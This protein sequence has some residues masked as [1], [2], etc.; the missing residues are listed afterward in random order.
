MAFPAYFHLECEGFL[1]WDNHL[2]SFLG[3]PFILAGVIIMKQSFKG[4]SLMH[5]LGLNKREMSIKLCLEGWNKRVRHPLYFGSIILIVGLFLFS[6]TYKMMISAIMMIVYFIVG[7]SFEEKRL[8]KEFGKQ[9]HDY[10]KSTPKLFPKFFLIGWFSFLLMGCST[11]AEKNLTAYVTL[12]NDSLAKQIVYFNEVPHQNLNDTIFL[13]TL[14]QYQFL[15]V[16]SGKGFIVSPNSNLEISTHQITGKGATQTL[17]FQG[18]QNEVLS[19]EDS[20]FSLLFNPN[21]YWK[22]YHYANQRRK[23]EY[24]KSFVLNDDELLR[25][26]RTFDLC[27]KI[28]N[29][30]KLLNYWAV[31][32]NL[33]RLNERIDSLGKN[34]NHIHNS[35]LFHPYLFQTVQEIVTVKGLSEDLSKIDS[36]IINLYDLELPKTGIFHFQL[37][38]N[39]KQKFQISQSELEHTISYEQMPNLEMYEFLLNLKPLNFPAETDT[40]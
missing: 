16:K 21:K 1:V 24:Q 12:E 36:T 20:L 23:S 19:S 15:G 11:N 33:F 30:K 27:F 9:Y 34:L 32:T 7:S 13:D 4:Y 6:P 26:F 25:V 28:R 31:D 8:L 39:W 14:N 38:A 29:A 17:Y 5:F 2:L 3:V 35:L 18:L 10:Q 22:W 37:L 40:L